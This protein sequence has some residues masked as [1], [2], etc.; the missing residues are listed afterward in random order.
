MLRHQIPAATA[1]STEPRPLEFCFELRPLVAAPFP[2]HRCSLRR[3]LRLSAPSAGLNP[4]PLPPAPDSDAAPNMH[5]PALARHQ[6]GPS[7][8]RHPAPPRPARKESFFLSSR[9]VARPALIRFNRSRHA[10][11]HPATIPADSRRPTRAARLGSPHWHPSHA[12]ASPLS[13]KPAVVVR[14]RTR[15]APINWAPAEPEA[16]GHL[17]WPRAE[18]VRLRPE[19]RLDRPVRAVGR[20]HGPA[21]RRRARVPHQDPSGGT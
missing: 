11:R 6:G 1:S 12:S 9:S 18:A 2:S 17:D 7:R 4:G 8:R 15:Q 20:Q 5:R 14:E 21:P 3:A 10:P 19:A 13:S 16:G